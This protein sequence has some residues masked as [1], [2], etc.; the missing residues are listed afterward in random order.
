[1]SEYTI[2]ATEFDKWFQKRV[3]K[4]SDGASRAVLLAAQGAALFA[5][6]TKM[7]KNRSGALRKSIKAYRTGK[8]S[9]RATAGTDHAFYIEN[10]NKPTGS[11][12]IRPKKAKALRFK[13]N[14]VVVFRKFVTPADPR[15]FM[16]QARDVAVPVFE[17][18]ALIAAKD[19]FE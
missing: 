12:V 14:G 15:P 16:R 3:T 2:E 4:L 11:N 8:F 7:F 17:R 19:A 6:Q 10:G 5:K 1:M 18:Y 13:L 9:A